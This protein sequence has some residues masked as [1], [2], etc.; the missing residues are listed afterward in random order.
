[1]VKHVNFVNACNL[2]FLSLKIQF[3]A[4]FDVY[5]EASA[6][7]THSVIGNDKCFVVFILWKIVEV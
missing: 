5:T 2:Q 4:F 7:S 1:M 3:E 6:E